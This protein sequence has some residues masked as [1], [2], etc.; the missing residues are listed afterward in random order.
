MGTP[1]PQTSFQFWVWEEE[2]LPQPPPSP[3]PPPSPTSPPCKLNPSSIV[4]L[5]DFSCFSLFRVV[6]FCQK[7]LSNSDFSQSENPTFRSKGR[8]FPP[9]PLL[10]LKLKL[11][12][13]PPS[14]FSKF[15]CFSL[16]SSLLV[17]GVLQ[18][19]CAH[20]QVCLPR[21]KSR[22]FDFLFECSR[23]PRVAQSSRPTTMPR[24]A[25]MPSADVSLPLFVEDHSLGHVQEGTL[26]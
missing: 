9:P 26:N 8:P 15:S 6:G 11:K 22:M 7:Y 14:I 1:K 13:K 12:L 25:S 21:R 2:R 4:P 10:L 18:A 5:F 20:G 23:G 24:F 17:R 19:G 3:H 16:C